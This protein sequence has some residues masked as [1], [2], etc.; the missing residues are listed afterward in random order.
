VLPDFIIANFFSLDSFTIVWDT[1]FSRDLLAGRVRMN[2]LHH[3][4][5]QGALLDRPLLALLV[6]LELNIDNRLN[7]ALSIVLIGAYRGQ[8]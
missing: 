6:K 7:S 4:L 1:N 8:Q 5:L 2:L 3:F